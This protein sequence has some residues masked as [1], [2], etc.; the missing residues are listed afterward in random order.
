MLLRLKRGAKKMEGLVLAVIG[1][2]RT[3]LMVTLLAELLGN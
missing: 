2:L 1:F 3:W